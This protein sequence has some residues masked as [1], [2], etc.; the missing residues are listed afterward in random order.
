MKKREYDDQ[1]VL[2]NEE[3]EAKRRNLM[4]EYALENNSV[5]VGDIIEDHAGRIKVDKIKVTRTLSS[6]YPQCIYEGEA[7]TK[8]GVPHKKS[9]RREVY[10]SNLKKDS[11]NEEE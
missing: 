9:F 10:Q 2:I 11:E 3:S 5:Q 4:I 8:K 1:M 7:L 6:R